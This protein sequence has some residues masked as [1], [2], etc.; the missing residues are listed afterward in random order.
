[1]I[2]FYLKH[3]YF[4]VSFSTPSAPP[5]IPATH[6]AIMTLESEY[7]PRPTSA[8]IHVHRS[9]PNQHTFKAKPHKRKSTYDSESSANDD[10]EDRPIPLGVCQV[11][12]GSTCDLY[13][14]NQSVFVPPHITIHILEERLK[15]AYGV[16]RESND[17]NANCRGY[18]LPSLCYS[19]LPICR[20]PART[21]HQYFAN[22]A[23]AEHYAKKSAAAK[24]KKNNARKAALIA[25]ATTTSTTSTTSTTTAET[26]TFFFQGGVTPSM[27]SATTFNMVTET[28]DPNQLRRRRRR[29][30]DVTVDSRT[31]NVRT[32][33]FLLHESDDV[34]V[35]V[36][37]STAFHPQIQFP[38][39]RTSEN[40]RRICRSEC[41]L[42]ENEL[43]QKEYAIA[44]RHPTIGQKLPLEDCFN[45][46]DTQD[47][48]QMGVA[49]ESNEKELCY[50]ET[51]AGYRGTVAVSASGKP[52]LHWARLMME[53]ANYPELAGQNYCR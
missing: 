35:G 27:T 14:R 29:S 6:Q 8:S 51:G 41:E 22:K 26:P 46:P 16:I 11:Y 44:K 21:N 45:L 18:A 48:S 34:L 42:L 3:P 4:F 25:A 5:K 30:F 32:N 28:M 33:H 31:K 52:C 12:S 38:P 37:E 49:I 53:I 19:I 17:M 9:G 39:T 15:A 20:T 43:C 40:L 23:N 2:F 36:A 7:E 50:W 1:M 13:L 10:E 24:Q 47:C